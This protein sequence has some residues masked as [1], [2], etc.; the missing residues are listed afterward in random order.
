MTKTFTPNDLIRFVYQETSDTENRII[1]RELLC[2]SELLDEY[3]E[4]R[5]AVQGLDEF[6]M[7]PSQS[8]ID[9]VLSFSKSLPLPS[10]SK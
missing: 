2:D 3:I 7:S 1:E 9:A 6:S 10:V 8:S 4:L 5:L